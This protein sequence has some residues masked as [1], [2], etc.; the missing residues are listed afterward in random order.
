MTEL[1]LVTDDLMAVCL[2]EDCYLLA[3]VDGKPLPKDEDEHLQYGSDND[4]EPHFVRPNTA[5]D[6]CDTMLGGN[7]YD[8]YCW[9]VDTAREAW[10]SRM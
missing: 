2:C 7:R 10:A 5:C 9:R 4:L 6:G 8:V 3:L 1:P